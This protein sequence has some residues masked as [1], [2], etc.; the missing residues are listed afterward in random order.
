MQEVAASATLFFLQL[1]DEAH[2]S[3]GLH[4]PLTNGLARVIVLHI[5]E[6][7][8]CAEGR[9]HGASYDE[10]GLLLLELLAKGAIRLGCV[11]VTKLV[12]SLANGI[13]SQTQRVL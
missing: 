7:L 1:A 4:T 11:N 3:F 13:P 5:A 8:P 10:H 6:C 9:A 12:D 2:V